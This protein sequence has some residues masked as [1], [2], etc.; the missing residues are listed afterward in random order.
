MK[1]KVNLK[2]ELY[3]IQVWLMLILGLGLWESDHMGLAI[4]VFLWAGITFINS[5]ILHI[6]QMV[7]DKEI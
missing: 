4:G 7:K 6:K 2:A 1:E 5:L 3:E